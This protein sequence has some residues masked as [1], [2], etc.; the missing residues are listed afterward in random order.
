MSLLFIQYIYTYDSMWLYILIFI[1]GIHVWIHIGQ[2]QEW[3]K[4]EGP[5]SFHWRAGLFCRWSQCCLAERIGPATWSNELPIIFDEVSPISPYT[6]WSMRFHVFPW[7][8]LICRFAIWNPSVFSWSCQIWGVH[9]SLPRKYSYF[10]R[11]V[12]DSVTR[13]HLFK[14]D[15]VI[16]WQ[17]LNHVKNVKNVHLCI[18][19]LRMWIGWPAWTSRP[20]TCWIC[21]SS[22][23]VGSLGDWPDSELPQIDDIRTVHM[24]DHVH[25]HYMDIM[26]RYMI[27]HDI[28]WYIMGILEQVKDMDEAFN[29][30]D[31]GE[32][33]CTSNS[34]SLG[35]VS[36][37]KLLGNWC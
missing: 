22:S 8:Y 4:W 14:S 27:Y 2:S 28:S 23:W 24:L 35:D 3:M 12:N 13:H 1:D 31:G 29:I 34:E 10:P 19:W 32:P 20:K 30:I 5:W 21:W 17:Q 18:S 25:L 16:P 9:I 37:G 7:L 36:C 11:D 33:G 26:D 6:K 15:T